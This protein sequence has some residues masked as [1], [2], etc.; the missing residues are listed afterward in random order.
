M[1][2]FSFVIALVA[3]VLCARLIQVYIETRNNRSRSAEDVDVE[4]TI[5]KIEAL[6]ERVRVLERIITEHRFDLEKQ[7]DNL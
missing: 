2:V 6:E 7:I 1:N 3:V 5:A 4:Q